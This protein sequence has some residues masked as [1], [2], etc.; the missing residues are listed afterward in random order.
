MKYRVKVGGYVTRFCQRNIIVY[1]KDEVDAAEK[2]KDKYIEL[3]MKIPN[4]FD[5]GTPIVE[6]MELIM[7]C[8]HG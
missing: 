5:A 3:E 2:A 8:N 6:S 4:S 1:A 7:R